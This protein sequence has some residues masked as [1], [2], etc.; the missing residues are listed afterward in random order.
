MFTVV[1]EQLG[2][3]LQPAV[4]PVELLVI[5]SARTIPIALTR[6]GLPSRSSQRATRAK[7]GGPPGDRTRDTLIKSQVLYH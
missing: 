1:Q 6:R 5:D 7:A 3:K 4:G 2:L